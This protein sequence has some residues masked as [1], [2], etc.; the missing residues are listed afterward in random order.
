[1]DFT[2]AWQLSENPPNLIPTNIYGNAH[3]YNIL[4]V[5]VQQAGLG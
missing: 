5:S 4:R 1:M 3:V 2:L